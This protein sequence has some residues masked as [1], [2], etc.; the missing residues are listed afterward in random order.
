MEIT[1]TDG[2]SLDC[3]VAGRGPVVVAAHGFPDHR[4]TFAL[5]V[6]ALVDAGFRVVCPAMRGYRPSGAGRAATATRLG[7][8]LLDIADAV[9]PDRAVHLL[10]H[11]WGAVAAYA[12]QA[13]APHRIR[14]LSTVAVPPLR[15]TVFR[16]FRPSQLRR[17]SY[18]L[19][20]QVSGAPEAWVSEPAFL[21]RLW[22]RWSPELSIDRAE[23]A[24][25]AAAMRPRA[26]LHYY[27]ELFRHRPDRAALAPIT[28]PALYIHGREDGCIGAELVDG[29]ESAFRGDAMIY[30]LSGGHFVHREAPAQ[31]NALLLRR[32]GGP[33]SMPATPG[34]GPRPPRP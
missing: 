19:R 32:M 29:I 15:P 13:L 16:Y 9:S 6:P 17:S 1:C 26:V 10:G 28:V 24:R 8:D 7:Q 11:D 33:D 31:V 12:A 21:E 4:E 25:I 3:L 30:T 27:R 2:V 34:V 22:R 14:T 20:F 23:L 18:I 5:Q